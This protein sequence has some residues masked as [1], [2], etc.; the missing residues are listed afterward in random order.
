MMFIDRIDAG[1]RLA[2]RLRYPRGRDLV[3]VGFPRGGVPVA[4]GVA[5]ALDAPLDVVVVRK[6]G[7]PFQPELGMGAIGQDGV[8]IIDEEI[9]RLSDVSADE[10]AAVEARERAERL[11]IAE[12]R[13]HGG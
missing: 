3:V 10:L 4:A 1:R 8:R 9:V 7:V 13:P 5:R 12:R 2:A 11:F 6:L